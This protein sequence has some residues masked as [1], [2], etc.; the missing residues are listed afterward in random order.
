M[1]NKNILKNIY[2]FSK[3]RL[4]K[5][6]FDGRFIIKKKKKICSLFEHQMK[7]K[8]TRIRLHCAVESS[9]KIEW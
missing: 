1:F 5:H 7:N 9:H 8:K 4:K 2:A 3:I 6:L